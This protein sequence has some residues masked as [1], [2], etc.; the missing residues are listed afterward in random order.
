MA[1]VKKDNVRRDIE[2]ALEY[3]KGSD[4]PR[5]YIIPVLTAIAGAAV[6]HG[7]YKKIVKPSK[8]F[9]RSHRLPQALETV[10]SAGIGYIVGDAV[11]EVIGG[12]N[13]LP[14]YRHRKVRK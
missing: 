2:T 14:G 11:N 1:D 13:T 4:N 10:S 6:G 12:E 9:A 7:L 5:D 8:R 3:H